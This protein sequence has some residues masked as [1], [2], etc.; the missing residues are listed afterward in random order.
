MNHSKSKLLADG[1]N[2][3]PHIKKVSGVYL[4]I[5]TWFISDDWPTQQI[6]SGFT[7]KE[8]YASWHKKL[9]SE[10]ESWSKMFQT[11]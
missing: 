10:Y 2:K 3:R 7:P 4:C 11:D 9:M 1:I 5:G 8:A 6:G